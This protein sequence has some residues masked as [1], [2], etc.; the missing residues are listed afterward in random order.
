MITRH[1]GRH[2][3]IEGRPGRRP[4][5][6]KTVCFTVNLDAVCTCP[7]SPIGGT[8]K[9][10]LVRELDAQ[11]G[12]RPGGGPACIQYRTLTG[13]RAPPLVP[14]ALPTAGVP[15]EHEDTLELQENLWVKH[16][17]VTDLIT[18]ESGAVDRV[19][20]RRSSCTGPAA[21]VCTAPIGWADIVA[22]DPGLRPRRH[23]RR[24]AA[25]P[26][27]AVGGAGAWRPFKIRHA[28]GSTPEAWIF[29]NGVQ[30]GRDGVP[31]PS[32]PRVPQNGRVATDYTTTHPRRDPGQPG[33]LPPL[34]GVIEGVG[35]G[36]AP[37][38]MT[39]GS[40]FADKPRHQSSSSQ[41]GWTRGALQPRA[42][43]PP[44]PED[45]QEEMLHTVAGLEIA[46]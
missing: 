16:A 43:P 23:G 32:R 41:W 5:G 11:G 22:T 27:P 18:D 35:P 24:P 42:S 10:N 14:A 39:R 3:G 20:R 28:S 17:E 36:T 26:E 21:V 30:P 46:R 6:L 15:E 13:A 19:R 9:G 44:L 8:G 7:Q 12:E 1:R 38:S 40:R 4:V 2:A 45:V 34:L 31:S 33:P 37:P 29:Q 25:D